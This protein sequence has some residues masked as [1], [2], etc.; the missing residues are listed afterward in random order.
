MTDVSRNEIR[1]VPMSLK[2]KKDL[3]QKL[4]Q[5]LIVESI[6]FL[7]YSFFG[8]AST[9]TYNGGITVEK[10]KLKFIQM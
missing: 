1:K 4:F 7:M 9:C 2:T 10:G 3:K 8:S 6:L 5:I